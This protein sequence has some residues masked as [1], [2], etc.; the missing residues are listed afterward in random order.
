ME[1]I[2]ERRVRGIEQP[3]EGPPLRSAEVGVACGQKVLKQH[4]EFQKA[5]AAAP[6]QPVEVALI[7][8]PLPPM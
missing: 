1:V 3:F 4:V 6:A 8:L 5:A 7:Q 2:Q